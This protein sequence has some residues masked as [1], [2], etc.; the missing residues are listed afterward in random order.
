MSGEREIANRRQELGPACQLTHP[1]FCWMLAVFLSLSSRSKAQVI[2]KF[3][4]N[5]QCLQEDGKNSSGCW[6]TIF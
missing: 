1:K 3:C 6:E 5:E 4:D 2:G